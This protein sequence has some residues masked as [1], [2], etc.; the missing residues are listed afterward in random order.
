MKSK[1]FSGLEAF[2]DATAVLQLGKAPM[3]YGELLRDADALGRCVRPRA[4]TFLVCQNSYE[5]IAAYVGLLRADAV[6]F[7]VHQ[8]MGDDHIAALEETFR[9]AYVVGPAR[10]KYAG[11][12][13]HRL[14]GYEVVETGREID[15][16]VHPD[17][18]LLLTTSGST[19]SS[20]L[21]RLTQHNIAENARAIGTYLGIHADDRPI[22]TMPMSYSYGMSII[23][24]HLVAGAAL[25]MSEDTLVTPAFWEAAKTLGATTFGGVPYLFDILKKLRFAKME[26]PALRYVT[27][28]G[29][30]LDREL[31]EWFTAVSAEKGF[32]FF[33]MYGQTEAAPRISYVPPRALPEKLG[34]IGQAVPGG[35][36]WLEDEDGNVITET[37]CPGELIFKGG[38][39]S[40]GYA[41]SRFELARGDDNGGILR[42]GDLAQRDAD[43]FY[44]IIGRK[45]RFLKIFGHRV[46]LDEV[47]KILAEAGYNTACTGTDGAL[48]IFIEGRAEAKTL[49]KFLF[50]RT[51][52]NPTAQKVVCI[53]EIPRNNAGKILY[54]ALQPRAGA[55]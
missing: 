8:S 15:Y 47:E 45:K 50:D 16:D 12:A 53:D 37:D 44:R 27:Q 5:A 38:N 34:T 3:S 4:L 51:G 52:I 7:L 20:S 36:I 33:V 46:N 2:S 22:T 14:G 54:P 26:L 10:A 9:P 11:K 43:G 49:K 25:I 24:S 35:E 31:A 21:V 40:L 19:G 1:I 28:A 29:G 6:L 42:T 18:A 32:E 23:N 30:N 41:E 48:Q 13:V 17:L 39:V 55:R